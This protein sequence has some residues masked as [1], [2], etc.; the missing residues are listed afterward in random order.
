MHQI[1][2]TDAWSKISS[3]LL[4][5]DRIRAILR[6]E[7]N[8]VTIIARGI[9]SGMRSERAGAGGISPILEVTWKTAELQG[10]QARKIAALNQEK[11]SDLPKRTR[12]IAEQLIDAGVLTLQ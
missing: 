4:D 9:A 8:P 6:A 1:G 11:C 2:P 10:R 5:L 12:R 3:G 7:P